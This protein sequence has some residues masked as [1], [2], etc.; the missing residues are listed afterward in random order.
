V[1][2]DEA[3]FHKDVR[4]VLDAVNALLI[5]GGKI[6]VISTHNGVLSPFN[7][8]IREA[9]AGKN[10][11]SVHFIPFG[12]AVKN[13]LYKRVCLIKGKQWSPKAEAEWEGNIRKSYGRALAADETGARRDPGRGRGRCAHPHAD[14][15]LHGC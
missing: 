12:E 2:I 8:L 7:E 10:P 1:V 5:W 11:F 4:G 6:R 14:R 3:A 9:R 15:K 13:G